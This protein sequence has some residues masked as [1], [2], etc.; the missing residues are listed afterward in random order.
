MTEFTADVSLKDIVVRDP[1]ISTA[2]DEPVRAMILDLLAG[3]DMTIS[4]LDAELSDRGYDR[5]EHTVRHHVNELREAGLVEVTQ[6][7]ERRGGITKYYR[8]N[9]VL[10]SYSVPEEDEPELAEMVEHAEAG[11]EELLADLT[12]EYSETLSG[13]AENMTPCDHCQPQ[14][15]ET[16]LLLTTLRRAF[17]QAQNNHAASTDEE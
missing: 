10:L 6:L 14:K 7:E 2:I 15:Y 16:Y 5:T 3:D 9:T 4:Q 13:I 11:I 17:V 8:A 1:T 12:A